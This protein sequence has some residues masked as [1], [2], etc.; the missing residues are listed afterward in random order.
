VITDFTRATSSQRCLRTD[1]LDKV[2]RTDCHHTFFEML[3]NFSFGDYFKKEAISWAWEFLTEELRI[4]GERLW[5]SVY[6][7]D[8]EAYN[9]WNNDIKI[10]ASKIVRLGDKENFWP[11]EGQGKGPN[12]PCGPCSEIFVDLGPSAGCKKSDCSPACSCGRFIEIWNLVFTQFNR[13]DNGILEPLPQKNIDTGMG[14]ERIT[15]VMQ[16]VTNNFQTDLFLPMIKE[17][18]A[19]AE[20][21][22]DGD[23]TEIYAVADHIRAITFAIFDGVMPSNE[24]RGYVVRKLIR[25]SLMHLRGLGIN[26]PFLYKLVPVLAQIMRKPNPGLALRRENIAGI[27]LAEEKNFIETLSSS[28][29]LLEEKFSGFSKS[30][31]ATEIGRTAFQLYDTHGIPLELTKGWLAKKGIAFSQDAFD[32][33][34][35]NRRNVPSC[36]ALCRARCSASKKL[37]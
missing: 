26:E 29:D 20:K 31:N 3:G 15:A 7:D 6:R 10:P 9:I 25:K 2:G 36:K 28:C 32:I 30:S 16:G 34:L 14:L 1:D 37:N 19:A 17:I 22:R 11:A 13:K 35:E 23:I 33:E 8:D 5:V 4:N 12:G 18:E 21:R 24:A 27:I